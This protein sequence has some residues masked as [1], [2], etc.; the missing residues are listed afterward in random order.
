MGAWPIALLALTLAVAPA[1]HAAAQRLETG[2]GS[3]VFPFFTAGSSR[4][5][6]VWYHRPAAAGPDAPVVFVMHGTGRNGEG[7]RR[8]W[9]PFADEGRYV[10]LVPEFSR[11]QFASHYNL[12]RLS[13]PDGTPV[14]R[15]QWPYASIDRIFDAVRAASGL[16]AQ[17]Y[18]LYGHSAGAQ[19]VHRLV[20]LVPD[21]RYRVAV[22]ANA[23]WYTLPDFATAYPYGLAGSGASPA[24]LSKALGR[25]LVVLLGDR[26]VD[27][28]H[29]DLRRTPG[30]MLQGRH[31]LERGQAFFAR[32]RQ[33][34]AETG[35]PF[36]WSVR[37]APGVAHSN[38]R[39][40]PHAAELVGAR[41]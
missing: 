14:P 17:S 30:A 41:D 3:F 10:L 34:A 7:Y 36:A 11:A 6:R 8:A 28:H 9:I 39:M 31:R 35:A 33:A 16:S 4:D 18:D 1:D 19:F 38:A 15:A 32:A 29:P 2:S 21:A 22:A 20:L 23:G 26:D 5:I 24:Q 12:E 40:A 13:L 27:P 37:I 25:K